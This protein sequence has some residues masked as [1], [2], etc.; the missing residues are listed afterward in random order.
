V[1]SGQWS[2][3]GAVQDGGRA[4]IA[5]ELR[6]SVYSVLSEFSVKVVRHTLGVFVG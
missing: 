6:S 4:P 2:V 5:D 3:D 1:G